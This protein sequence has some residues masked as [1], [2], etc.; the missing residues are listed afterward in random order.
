MN[1]ALSIYFRAEGD[2]LLAVIKAFRS[3]NHF[4]HFRKL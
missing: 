1:D 3:A 4:D 2:N